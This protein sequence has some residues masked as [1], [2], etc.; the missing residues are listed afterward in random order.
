MKSDREDR[1]IDGAQFG[2]P[3]EGEGTRR[4]GTDVSQSDH[5]TK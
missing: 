5:S 2:D 4:K 3:P 1:E